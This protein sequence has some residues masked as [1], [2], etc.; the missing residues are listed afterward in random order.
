MKND[1]LKNTSSANTMRTFPRI[2]IAK[3]KLE[4]S[5]MVGQKEIELN[6]TAMGNQL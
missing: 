6:L 1:K 5:K 4:M 2:E 3:L